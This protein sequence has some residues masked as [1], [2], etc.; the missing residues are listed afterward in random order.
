MLGGLTLTSNFFGEIIAR[1]QKIQPR[2]VCILEGGYNLDWIGKCLVSQLGQMTSHPVT[3][4]DL[5][6]DYT[7]TAESVISEI[8]KEISKYWTV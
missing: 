7:N 4:D 6:D 8:K 1:L 5:V 2:I 3:F